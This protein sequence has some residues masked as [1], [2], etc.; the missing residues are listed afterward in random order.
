MKNVLLIL[1]SLAIVPAKAQRLKTKRVLQISD[2][3]LLT[4]TNEVLFT[5]FRISEGSYYR[6]Q[7][8]K[9]YSAAGKFLSK[10]DLKR[11]TTEIWMLYH[12]NHPEINGVTNGTWVKLDNNL[13]LVDTVALDFIPD[14]LWKNEPANFIAKQEALRLA[15]KHF[16]RNGIE[17]LEPV[18]EYSDSLNFYTYDVTNVL[19]KSKNQF[20][21][22]AGQTEVVILNAVSGE[23]IEKFK[24]AYGLII[25]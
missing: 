12:F 8:R 5:H 19:T 1:L 15:L 7:K 3:I 23:L 18:L 17:I 21:K 22:D 9:R 13:R 10:K 25:R 24:A 11:K 2:S 4:N 16:E 20:G 6:Y 14:F